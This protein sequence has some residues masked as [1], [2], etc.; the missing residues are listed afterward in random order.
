[1]VAAGDYGAIT[2][3]VEGS[4]CFDLRFGT[5]SAK[6][7]T[8]RWG[9]RAPAGTYS[10]VVLNADMTRSFVSEFVIAAGEANTDVVRIITVPGDQAGTWPTGNVRG[11]YLRWCVRTGSSYMQAPGTWGTTNTVGSP[12]QFN[13]CW[14]HRGNVFELFD[15]AM[16]EGSAAPNY[17]CPELATEKWQC[18]R[19]FRYQTSSPEVTGCWPIDLTPT[20]YRRSFYQFQPEMRASAS[21]DADGSNHRDSVRRRPSASDVNHAVLVRAAGRYD[22]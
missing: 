14:A 13:F 18:L 20:P 10:M 4:R 8:L 19:Y 3:F 6:A 17:V 1:M 22:E 11:F 15:V 16:Y 2:Q 7:I 9:C 21:G 12:N 5:T